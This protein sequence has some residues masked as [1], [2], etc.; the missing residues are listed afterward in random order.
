MIS[1]NR[2]VMVRKLK[3]TVVT[4]NSKYLT[5]EDGDGSHVKNVKTG[6]E[7]TGDE[8]VRKQGQAMVL[9]VGKKVIVK[10][11]RV[12]ELTFLGD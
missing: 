4:E 12:I 8:L 6:E 5:W 1:R 9:S 2:F 11:S 10:T 7:W 3:L